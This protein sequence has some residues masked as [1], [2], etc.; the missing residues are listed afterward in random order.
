MAGP[1]PETDRLFLSHVVHD[2]T[3]PIET[4]APDLLVPRP[5][6]GENED[7]PAIF[8]GLIA[9]ANQ[10]MKDA[11]VRDRYAAEKNVLCFEMEAAGL[12]N[13]F[14]CLVIRGICDYSDSHK[15]KQ[16]Q[17]YAAMTA[18]AYAKALISVVLPTKVENERRLAEIVEVG[19]QNVFEKM[20]GISRSIDQ[21][22]LNKLTVAMD[23]AYDSHKEHDEPKCLEGTRV[24]I[25]SNIMHWAHDSRDQRIFWLNGMAGTGKSTISRTVAKSCYSAG[26]LGA[27][28]F[29]RRGESHRSSAALLFS[30]IARQLASRRPDLKLLIGEAVKENLDIS[31]KGISEQFWQLIMTPLQRS[32][33]TFN[34][35]RSIII[36]DAVDECATEKDIEI[37][38]PLLSNVV[39]CNPSSLKIFIT[40]RPETSAQYAFHHTHG[41]LQEVILQEVTKSVID[42]DIELFLKYELSMIRETWNSIHRNDSSKQIGS[43]WPEQEKIQILLR[44]ARPLFI[45]AATACRFVRDYRLGDPEEQLAH[46]IEA[47]KDSGIND[48]LD[49]TYRPVLGKF[50]TVESERSRKILLHDFHVIVGAIILLEEPLPTNSV[51]PLVSSST[52]RVDRICGLLRSVLDIPADTSLPI[53][54]L[55]A[56][57]RDFLISPSAEA[58]QI[59]AGQ[60][61]QRIAL[62][63][64]RLLSNHDILRYNMCNIRPGDRTSMIPKELVEMRFPPHLRYACLHWPYHLEHAHEAF[65]HVDEIY[66]FLQTHLLHWL[67]ALSVLGEF[68]KAMAMPD[69]LINKLIISSKHSPDEG[70]L[71]LLNDLKWFMAIHGPAIIDHPLHLYWGAILFSPSASE[72]RRTFISKVPNSVAFFEPHDSVWSCFRLIKASSIAHNEIKSKPY[73]VAVS[74][75]STLIAYGFLNGIIE[76]VAMSTGKS[77]QVIRDHLE[78]PMEP[79]MDTPS[80]PVNSLCF[81][82]DSA[83]I[84]STSR[85]TMC[86]H[87][88]NG[89]RKQWWKHADDYRLTNFRRCS[90]SPDSS[91]LASVH[92][93]K[94]IL[95]STL[96][97][98]QLMVLSD[99]GPAS[100]GHE[101]GILHDEVS[102]GQDGFA[103]F[104]PD[105]QLLA[106]SFAGLSQIRTVNTGQCLYTFKSDRP[107][108]CPI[109]FATFANAAVRTDIKGDTQYWNLDTGVCTHYSRLGWRLH[110]PRA[111]PWYLPRRHALS[112]D[113]RLFAAETRTNSGH[114]IF[115]WNLKT[116]KLQWNIP[117]NCSKSISSSI[118][119]SPDGKYLL[120]SDENRTFI[121]SLSLLDLPLQNS[122]KNDRK[123]HQ[124]MLTETC[125]VH[126]ST[127][128]E[129]LISTH[130]SISAPEIKFWSTETGE[131]FK[132]LIS[133]DPNV[134]SHTVALSRNMQYVFESTAAGSCL[135]WTVGKSTKLHQVP[136]V[137]RT[138]ISLQAPSSSFMKLPLHAPSTAVFAEDSNAV[139]TVSAHEFSLQAV[140]SKS[141]FRHFTFGANAMA[142]SAGWDT[143]VFAFRVPRR[144]RHVFTVIIRV[145]NIRTK[146]HSD[147]LESMGVEITRLAIS[148]NSKWVCSVSWNTLESKPSD[149]RTHMTILSTVGQSSRQ[150]VVHGPD[151][152]AVAFSSGSDLLASAAL[153]KTIRIWSVSEGRCIHIFT[154]GFVAFSLSFSYDSSFLITNY[155]K[156]TTPDS[157]LNSSVRNVGLESDLE[158]EAPAIP[159]KPKSI[160]YGIDLEGGWITWNGTN[161]ML[162]PGQ[163]AIGKVDNHTRAGGLSVAIGDHSVSWVDESS[164]NLYTVGFRKDTTPFETSESL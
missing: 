146:Q 61:H 42:H 139:A 15:N 46:I 164:K 36:I 20:S 3:N 32:R 113:G 110:E 151:I 19:L 84:A 67:E 64:L 6:R 13:H 82:A 49:S 156:L 58:F 137:S 100:S 115:I 87:T 40:S 41:E 29:F 96:T 16:W 69:L 143:A 162:L 21:E 66:R 34:G 10:L 79:S 105:S 153:D 135:M 18:A 112:H 88:R 163:I 23:A 142:V 160:G 50:L 155:G 124:G 126:K 65:K 119:F 121:W 138:E 109:S 145:L 92:Q 44:L 72:V 2:P 127:V 86:F 17:G 111:Q 59:D 89:V 24:D 131:V 80:E 125:F 39:K 108:M 37:L 25:L 152:Q 141:R 97:G 57:F 159:Q 107:A 33:H 54:L 122:G 150:L 56:S 114:S 147:F 90:L 28:F 101:D 123:Q 128:G 94:V 104:S 130:A 30:T 45:F 91:T 74:P 11:N 134:E 9:S 48:G 1:P 117:S 63:C 116:E 120:D 129:V 99:M 149:R 136:P 8:Y 75:D 158:A 81:S 140:E 157:T 55:H 14:P 102:Y 78:N 154:V 4:P 144:Y 103:S 35:T 73:S 5:E 118:I 106:I 12:M 85:C 133:Q 83:C 47:T 31:S 7:D 148:P 27:T 68:R 132:T 71:K 60:S 22:I 98:E 93:N 26:I 77:L 76:L 95:W 52:A 43:I 62:G 38:I 161:I 70:L 53:R 51:A